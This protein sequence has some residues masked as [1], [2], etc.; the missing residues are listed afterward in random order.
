M[1]KS[2]SCTFAILSTSEADIYTAPSRSMSLLVQA[3]NNTG[4]SANCELWITD[5]SDNHLYPLFPSQAVTLYNGIS[6]N[7]KHIISSGYKIR[8]KSDTLDAIYVEVNM[9]EGL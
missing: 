7:G 8:G 2:F 9:I 4:T 5:S 3:A 6:D 1:S